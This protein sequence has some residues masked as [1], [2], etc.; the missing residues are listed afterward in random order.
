NSSAD[1]ETASYLSRLKKLQTISIAGTKI[2]AK[3]LLQSVLP[4]GIRIYIGQDQFTNNELISL[5]N[6][7]PNLDSL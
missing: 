5:Q 7:F 3:G 6:M 2:T 1:D 4:T